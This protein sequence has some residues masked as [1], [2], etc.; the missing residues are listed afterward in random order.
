LLNTRGEVVGINTAI[1]S[2]GGGNIGIGFA[3][4][5]SLAKEI[6]PQL[7][8]KGHVTRGWLGVMIQKVTPDIADSLGLLSAKGALVADVVKEGPAEAVGIKQGDVI[9]EYDGKPV[10]DSAELPLL[11]ARTA[12]GKT[13]KL[14]VI[15]DKAEQTFSIKIAELKE[16]ETAQAGPGTAEDMGLTVQTLTPEVAENLGLD[17]SLKGVVVTQVDAGGPAADAGLRRG[18][19]RRG[20]A[21]LLGRLVARCRARP[22]P[23]RGHGARLAPPC[24]QHAAGDRRRARPGGARAR[25]RR[26]HRGDVR[27]RTDR[28]SPGRA[29]GGEG[30]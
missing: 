2:R 24:P 18:G 20:G 22:L 9:V 3:I 11:V 28:L 8:E 4:P 14:K 19:A 25:R 21:S 27:T 7:K 30:D 26:R 10:N 6:V 12:V 1:F 5:I 15:R 16:E 23:G 29:L 17:R 13:V